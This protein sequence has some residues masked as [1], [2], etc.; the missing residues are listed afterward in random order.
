MRTHSGDEL[1]LK[2]LKIRSLL[3]DTLVYG[4][5]DAVSKLA[6]LIL[7]PALTFRLSPEQ[8]GASSLLLMWYTLAVAIFGLGT[9]ASL[10]PAYFAAK[11]DDE[12]LRAIWTAVWLLAVSS[13]LLLCIVMFGNRRIGTILFG[14]ETIYARLVVLSALAAAV[15]MAAGP[16]RLRLQFKGDP[17][18]YVLAGFLGAFVTATSTLIAVFV[19]H[20]GVLGV[21]AGNLA[22]QCVLLASAVILVGSY[23]PTYST[24]IAKELLKVG[25]PL[26]PSFFVIFLLTQ[27]GRY[28][29]SV[30]EGLAAAG[31]YTT[32]T[33]LGLGLSV[34]VSALQAAWYPFFMQF[35]QKAEEAKPVFARIFKYYVYTY[36]GLNLLFY[37]LARPLVQFVISGQYADAVYGIGIA[38]T[39]EFARGA[40][41]L[42]L[43]PVYFSRRLY[44]VT[45]IQSASALVAIAMCLVAVHRVGWLGVSASLTLANVVMV[46]LHYLWNSRVCRFTVPYEFR[47]ICRVIV[48]YAISA[49]LLILAYR[50]SLGPYILASTVIVLITVLAIYGTLDRSERTRLEAGIVIVTNIAV[51]RKALMLGFPAKPSTTSARQTE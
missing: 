49:A 29:T 25:L 43:P 7:L 50:L 13:A 44:V 46:V 30:M 14:H 28:I 40:A 1:G 11:T 12:R 37:V 34:A 38:A 3:S 10:G 27:A 24:A 9:G 42:L 21:V 5:G 20:L 47:R 18:R 17:L 4:G 41:I 2:R 26:V 23:K 35:M 45:L 48:T 16:F 19:M 32:A 8:M 51:V 6:S 36:G 39:A 22:G 33:N 31:I 15:N